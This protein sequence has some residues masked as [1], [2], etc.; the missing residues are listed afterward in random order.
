MNRSSATVIGF[1]GGVLAAG[2]IAALAIVLV[3]P[4]LRREGI[5]WA[6]AIVVVALSTWGAWAI[7]SSTDR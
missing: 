1:V 4:A 6:T 5:V 2:V 3:P 7:S